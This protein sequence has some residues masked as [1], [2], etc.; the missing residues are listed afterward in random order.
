VSDDSKPKDYFTQVPEWILFA[1]LSPQALALYVVLLA[2][3]N[4]KDKKDEAF[5]GMDTLAEILSFG[6]R[7]SLMRYVAEL[8]A[9][10]VVK[11]ERRPCATGKRNYYTVLKD[12]PPGYSGPP[13]VPEFHTRRKREADRGMS[14]VGDEGL[15]LP[16]DEGWS[17]VGDKN[18]TNGTRRTERDEPAPAGHTSI[19]GNDFHRG[20]FSAAAIAPTKI[21]MPR[22]F[23]DLTEEHVWQFLVKA[24]VGCMRPH[25]IEL[26][27]KAKGKLGEILKDSH[28]GADRSSL[29]V[30]LEKTIDGA[31]AGDE[32]F[33]W[34][35]R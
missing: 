4:R 3:V 31:L 10:G 35:L 29:V 18:H 25:G 6:K 20:P 1:G 17:P 27:E 15:S 13:S 9:L 23:A 21:R 34:L 26:T 30:A 12:M 8:R 32:R 14:P 24:A 16:G 2:H 22:N 11:V 33:S 5:I 7:Q 19:S 28:R